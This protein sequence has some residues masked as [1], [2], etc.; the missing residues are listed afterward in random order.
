MGI[1]NKLAIIALMST[2]ALTSCKKEPL[3]EP[4]QDTTTP[5]TSN[6]LNWNGEGLPPVDT[7]SV[8]ITYHMAKN[9]AVTVTPGGQ[10]VSISFPESVIH[11]PDSITFNLGMGD[12]FSADPN[13]ADGFR[14]MTYDSPIAGYLVNAPDTAYR[15][16][17]TVN[18]W[19]F[20]N[21]QPGP[22]NPPD[23]FTFVE[24]DANGYPQAVRVY[25]LSTMTSQ[26]DAT[27]STKALFFMLGDPDYN[28]P[29]QFQVADRI[30]TIVFNAEET[31]DG[32]VAFGTCNNQTT[33]VTCHTPSVPVDPVDPVD[34]PP[35]PPPIPVVNYNV[36]NMVIDVDVND[37]YIGFPN[38]IMT[39]VDSLGVVDSVFFSPADMGMKL[40]PYNGFGEYW[41][42]EEYKRAG[43]QSS[44]TQLPGDADISC[45]YNGGHGFVIQTPGAVRDTMILVHYNANGDQIIDK[46]KIS[47]SANSNDIVGTT[48]I[49]YDVSG[50]NGT[51]GSRSCPTADDYGVQMTQNDAQWHFNGL[52]NMQG[53]RFTLTY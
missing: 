43:G 24:R 28:P 49:M 40:I 14:T 52:N 22:G 7:S 8:P 46:T 37:T 15:T 29:T 34:P 18:Q 48:K 27:Q 13:L 30:N 5:T 11:T 20:K 41:E 39:T 44:L 3:E 4:A 35:P 25:N 17:H 6:P 2:T 53:D 23:R 26:Q 42:F 38:Q 36:N 10:L 21:L 47:I 50:W 12:T 1:L 33:S 45:A 31:V 16:S 51:P 19:A 9:V 32:G